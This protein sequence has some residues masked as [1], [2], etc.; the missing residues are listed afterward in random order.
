MASS[1][2]LRDDLIEP[3]FLA[4]YGFL[5]EEYTEQA[6]AY[7]TVVMFRKLFLSVVIVFLGAGSYQKGLQVLFGLGVISIAIAIHHVVLPF[8]DVRPTDDVSSRSSI[9]PSHASVI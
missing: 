8:T 7:E 5:Y 4:R 3:D 2:F 9:S 6:Y 1:L